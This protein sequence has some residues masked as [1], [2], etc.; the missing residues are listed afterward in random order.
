MNGVQDSWQA[1]DPYDYFMGRWSRL[2]ARDFVQWLSPVPGLKWLDVGCGSGALSENIIQ[3]CQPAELI[4]VDQSEGF[5]ATAQKRLGSLAQCK[6]GNALALPIEAASVNFTVSGLV[7]NFI[8]QPATALAEMRRV[9]LPGGA[10]AVYIWD[11]AGQMAFLRTFWDAA[12]QLDPQASNLHESHRFADATDETLRALFQR[13]GFVNIEAVSIEIN[14]I[15]Q[16]FDDYWQPFLGGQG[17]A[18]SYVQH[19]DASAKTELRDAVYE[20]LPIRADG[21][22]AM[23]A[24]AWATRGEVS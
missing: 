12:V 8:A 4:A 18:P 24:R 20:R 10:V 22:I 2:V 23:P 11:Y 5:V 6:V 7:L 21:S 9:T 1:G 15:F 17:P 19:L 3:N 16:N 14:M 13:A